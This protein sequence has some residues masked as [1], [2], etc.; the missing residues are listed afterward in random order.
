MANG[1]QPSLNSTEEQ[2]LISVK[3]GCCTI[4]VITK[5]GKRLHL[6][7]M[8]SFPLIPIGAL[9]ILLISIMISAVQHK[10]QV[11]TLKNQVL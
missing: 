2:S 9:T 7:Q 4:D 8:L 6:L 10:R 5:Q 11:I 3:S 1:S